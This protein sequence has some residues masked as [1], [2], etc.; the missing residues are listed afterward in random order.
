MTPPTVLVDAAGIDSRFVALLRPGE[1]ASLGRV[2]DRRRNEFATGRALLRGLVGEQFEFLA[3]RGGPPLLPVGWVGSI[4]HDDAVAVVA[5]SS[6][7]AIESIGIDIEPTTKLDPA[8]SEMIL[9]P[10]ELG[11]DAHLAFTLKEATYKAWSAAGGEFLEHHD[12]RL[13]VRDGVFTA[14]ILP[15]V[16]MS[17]DHNIGTLARSFTGAFAKVE[18]G[19]RSGIRPVGSRWVAAAVHPRH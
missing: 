12:V 8:M 17:P 15:G 7:P 9:R 18:P 16:G 2:A 4:A 19:G 13:T 5:V 3:I 14:E 10:D 11:I 6:H 1:V